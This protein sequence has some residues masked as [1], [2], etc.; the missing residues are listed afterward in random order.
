MLEQNAI[1]L[2][3]WQPHDAYVPSIGCGFSI[4]PVPVPHRSEFS[5]CH[6]LIIDSGSKSLLF[7]PDHDSWSETLA[8]MSIRQ[9]LSDLQVDVALIDGTFWS[10]DELK[11]RDMSEIPH[12]PVKDTLGRLGQ[13]QEHD[14]DIQ[15]FHLNHTNPLCDSESAEW[16]ELHSLGWSVACEGDSFT[17][18][19]L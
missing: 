13:R 15:F 14:P 9:W 12:P 11:N 18:E 10:G 8:N 17:L 7:M 3:I 4:R 19:R 6:A 2:E 1:T 5:D 16:K